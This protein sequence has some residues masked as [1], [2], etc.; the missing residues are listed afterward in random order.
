[1][2]EHRDPRVP[3]DV[4]R[5]L[6]LGFGVDE[7]VIAVGVN[8]GQQGLR[9]AAG[10]QGHDGGQV[11]ALGETGSVL[12]E[13]QLVSATEL[14]AP[15]SCHR[16][17]SILAAQWPYTGMRTARAMVWNLRLKPATAGDTFESIPSVSGS[18][19]GT[20]KTKRGGGGAPG[21]APPPKSLV[22]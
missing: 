19:A 21:G 13:R 15:S 14:S 7:Q 16:P 5:P 2:D 11:R 3:A 9:L 1:M 22:P 18:R 4:L 17:G 10:H 12:I 20:A 6:T 8:P